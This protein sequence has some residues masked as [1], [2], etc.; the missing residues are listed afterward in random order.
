M[1]K[2]REYFDLC[3]NY[4]VS[5]G[6]SKEC[7]TIRALWWDCAEVWNADK[8]WDDDKVKF[9]NS[10]RKYTPYGPIPEETMVSEGMA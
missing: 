10:Y 7:A 8:S 9:F 5:T 1:D 2:I 3:V 6:I 4:W